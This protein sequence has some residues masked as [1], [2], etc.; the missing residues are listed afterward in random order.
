VWLE[1]GIAYEK[2][3]GL[4]CIVVERNRGHHNPIVRAA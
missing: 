1:L 2:R 4:A 3:R